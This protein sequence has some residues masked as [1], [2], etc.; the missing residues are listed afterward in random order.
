[1]S[2]FDPKQTSFL[3]NAR[4]KAVA[5][6]LR[7]EHIS[8]VVRCLVP[9]LL[10]PNAVEMPC[11]SRQPI[12]LG[13]FPP[14]EP[15]REP[16]SRWRGPRT[17]LA[18]ALGGGCC[19]YSTGDIARFLEHV[20]GDLAMLHVRAALLLE[21]AARAIVVEALQPMRGLT[22]RLTPTSPPSATTSPS[23]RQSLIRLN[24]CPLSAEWMRLTSEMSASARQ[25]ISGWA[26]S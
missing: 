8:V 1:M 4:D 16:I 9:F 19:A 3:R 23:T 12:A 22:R 7:R 25:P 18:R 13:Q 26:N 2:A 14:S 17:L 10:E 24:G 11:A 21:R 5:G 20:P 6:A 15:A